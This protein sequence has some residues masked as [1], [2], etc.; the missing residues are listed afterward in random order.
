MGINIDLNRIPNIKLITVI[1]LIFSSILAPF[2]FLFQ[3]NK[4]L[5]YKI[6]LVHLI[7]ISACIGFP[8]TIINITLA[9]VFSKFDPDSNDYNYQI[10]IYGSFIT[11][12]VLY[13]PCIHTLN[14]K[15]SLPAATRSANFV[16]IGVILFSSIRFF[17]RSFFKKKRNHEKLPNSTD[18]VTDPVQNHESNA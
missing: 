15:I 8:L 1:L 16:Q 7:L 4:P 13:T 11:I 12:C 3:F 9:L 18:P 5:F 14:E 6:D 17:M 10:I 2:W